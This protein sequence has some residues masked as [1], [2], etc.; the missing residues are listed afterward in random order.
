MLRVRC[1]RGNIISRG[2]MELAAIRAGLS[3]GLTAASLLSAIV[4]TALVLL[5]AASA[6]SATLA[7]TMFVLPTFIE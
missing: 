4:I 1:V 5:A 3:A 6:V 7:V 2:I